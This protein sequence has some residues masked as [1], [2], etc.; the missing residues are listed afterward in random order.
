MTRR[1]VM[2]AVLAGEKL[3]HVPLWIMAFTG[4]DLLENLFPEDMLYSGLYEYPEKEGNY[5]FDHGSDEENLKKQIA[6]SEYIDR[7]A[8]HVGYGSMA[9]GGHGGP[10]EFNKKIVERGERYFVAQYETGGLKKIQSK[11]FNVHQYGHPVKTMED[12]EALVLPDSTD[13][14][15][16]VGFR[17]SVEY[18]K[19]HDQWT[20]G[21]IN[22][23]FSGVHYFVM[24]FQTM[25]GNFLVEPELV[26]ACIEKVSD[27]TL[28]AAQKMCE[29]G[30]D[31]LYWCDD[32]GSGTS[33]LVSPE[34]YRE[35]IKPY[36]RKVTELAHSY[37][38][39]VHMHSHGAIMPIL[40]DLVDVGLDMIN[41][42]DPDDQMPFEAAKPIL[43]DKTT[44]VGGINKHFFDWDS[45]KKYAYLKDIMKKGHDAG[46][47]ILMDSAGLPENVTKEAY[48][49]FMNM[50]HDINSKF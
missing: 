38:V 45:N 11:P 39:K 5:L 13:D 18:A 21:M 34:M 14:A 37:G 9:A 26:K 50:Y 15:R 12:L 19:K 48:T 2:E 40:Q 23:V 1:E 35:F 36:H 42:F 43:A 7:C 49:E 8:F 32:L 47:F 33:L 10:G 41:P 25:L 4:W 27:W 31:C 20:V 6:F 24:D 22:G 46:R 30:V 44:M 28:G 3:D 29:A 17:K 16:Y